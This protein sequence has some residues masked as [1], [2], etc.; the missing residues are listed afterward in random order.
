MTHDSCSSLRPVVALVSALLCLPAPGARAAGAGDTFD[1]EP[2]EIRLRRF[3]DALA[4]GV[5]RLGTHPRYSTV[6]VLPFAEHGERAEDHDLGDLLTYTVRAAMARDYGLPVVLPAAIR[7]AKRALP[8]DTVIGP[9]EARRLGVAVRAKAVIMGNV[10]DSGDHFAMSASVFASA[11]RE[12]PLEHRLLRV[13]VPELITAAEEARILRTKPGALWRS[14]VLPGWG[15][16]YNRDVVEGVLVSGAEV[17]LL[18]AA[19]VFE[20]LGRRAESRYRWDTREAVEQRQA[21]LDHYVLRNAL[22]AVA[23]GVWLFGAVHAWLGGADPDETPTL[24]AMPRLQVMPVVTASAPG[25]P[26]FTGGV[27]LVTF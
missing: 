18:S 24:A 14:L 6:A 12:A 8:P 16:V 9:S 19:V 13:R 7:E 4:K 17:G 23:G 10:S 25:R 2:L 22:L 26:A 11:G 27:A 15:Q 21:A 3:C 20:V 5:G 1:A